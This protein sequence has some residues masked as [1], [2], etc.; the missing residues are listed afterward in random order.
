MDAGQN[1]EPEIIN[2]DMMKEKMDVQKAVE[3]LQGL[4]A[5][6]LD[7]EE[8]ELAEELLKDEGV[9]R[10]YEELG[11]DETLVEELRRYGQFNPVRGR[12]VFEK[13]LQRQ[14]ALRW[15]K[16]LAAA[17][18]VVA[19]LG[20]GWLLWQERSVEPEAVVATGTAGV[21]EN[22]LRLR[23]ANGEERIIGHDL[24][25][26]IQEDGNTTIAIEGGNLSYG[27]G[28]DV[29]GEEAV[30]GYNELYVPRGSECSLE[31]EDGTKVWLNADTYLKYPVRFAGNARRVELRGEGY[32]E[33]AKDGRAFSVQSASG[34][35]QVMGTSFCVRDYEGEPAMTTLVT[36]KVAFVAP[37]GARLELEPGEQAYVAADGRLEKREVDVREFTAWREGWFVFR[38]AP[39]GEVMQMMCRWY[40]VEVFY[41]SPDIQEM[42][43]TGNLKRYSTIETFLKLLS[44][45][46]EIKYTV[47]GKTVVLYK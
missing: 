30:A 5:G 24:Q 35:V 47:K 42:R 29:Q 45:P 14:R 28:E 1:G 32:F 25:D 16:R 2:C 17:A 3:L 41:Q 36:G 46:C 33:V 27:R 22:A 7:G 34:V 10:V 38:E 43:F 21:G 6:R 15:M 19:A 31:L 18:C 37:G 12:I 23:L 20:G 9:R 44:V 4:Y 39:L 40:D 26:V 11:D 13:R 8:Q